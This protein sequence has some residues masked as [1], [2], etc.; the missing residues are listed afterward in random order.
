M[1][2]VVCELF[3][4]LVRQHPIFVNCLVCQAQAA[5][6]KH[7]RH[8]DFPR[9]M[10]MAKKMP[11]RRGLSWTPAKRLSQAKTVLKHKK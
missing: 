7:G 10:S 9:L 5:Y 8:V 6:E 1:R 3:S 2:H 11:N 4:P